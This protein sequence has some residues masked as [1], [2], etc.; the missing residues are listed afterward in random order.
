M[1]VRTGS[2]LIPKLMLSKR[3]VFLLWGPFCGQRQALDAVECLTNRWLLLFL[4]REEALSEAVTFHFYSKI[5]SY[6]PG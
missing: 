3:T 5:H 6:Y 1:N 4:G 2:V